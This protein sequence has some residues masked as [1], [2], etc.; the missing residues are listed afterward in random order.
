MKVLFAASEVNPFAKVGGLADVMGS[1]PAALKKN[2]VDARVIM[3]KY[4]VI[5]QQYKDRME[6]V[7][8]TFVSLGWRNQY[9]GLMRMNYNGVTVY[10]VDNEYYF[11]GG[12]VYGEMCAEA[13]KY[14]FFCKAVLALLPVMGFTPDIL[15]CNDWQT[16]MI[17]VLL[18]GNMRVLK[19]NL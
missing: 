11:H 10:F 14:A 2:G 8:Y 16:G 5:A 17:P 15:H 12:S 3:P 7:G 18:K 6:Y 1:L 13:E 19:S 9:A 4:S